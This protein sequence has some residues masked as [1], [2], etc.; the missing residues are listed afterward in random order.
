MKNIILSFLFGLFFFTSCN[1]DTELLVTRSYGTVEMQGHTT[2]QY[3]THVLLDESGYVLF[4]L[5]SDKLNL[6][7]YIGRTVSLSGHLVKG[8]PVENGPEYLEVTKV[9]E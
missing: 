4:A 3:G 8:Y 9:K 6:D 5:R 7:D 2:Y 1:R